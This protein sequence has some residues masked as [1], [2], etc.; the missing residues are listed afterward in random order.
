MK[1]KIE[2]LL[3]ETE[4]IIDNTGIKESYR[5]AA[6]RIVFK[7]LWD[8]SISSVAEVTKE[9]QFQQPLAKQTQSKPLKPSGLADNIR[10]LVASDSFKTYK[11]PLEVSKE[12][13]KKAIN[14]NTSAVSVALM[15][16]TRS[17]LL[18]RDGA[19]TTKDPWRY[20]ENKEE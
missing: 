5:S 15:R 1:D 10:N 3:L 14:Y 4:K 16:L 20:K 2:K 11:S 17:G 19:G 12:L 8:S 6:F 7:I 13:K 9:G 18:I